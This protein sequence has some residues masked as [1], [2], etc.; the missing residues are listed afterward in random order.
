MKPLIVANWKMNPVSLK[1]AKEL[2]DSVAKRLHRTWGFGRR[3]RKNNY[4][5]A[6]KI[7]STCGK[8]RAGEG[9]QRGKHLYYRCTDWVY[10]FPLAPTCLEKGISARVLDELVWKEIIKIINSPELIA[11]QADRW[12]EGRKGKSTLSHIS[13]SDVNKEIEKL[14]KEEERYVKAYGAAVITLEQLKE[15]TTGI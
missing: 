9:P 3:N 6:G 13:V 5:L 8:K 15:H 4:L 11:K 7:Y 12:L 1:E 10:S 14:R 2:F